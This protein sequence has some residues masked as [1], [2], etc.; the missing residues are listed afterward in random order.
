M[1]AYPLAML[2]VF[3]WLGFQEVSLPMK[4]EAPVFYAQFSDPRA[5]IVFAL[6]LLVICMIVSLHV[7]RSRFGMSLIAIKQNEPAAS[8]AGINALRWKMLAMMVSAGMGAAAGGLMPSCCSSSR[9]RR[10]SAHG[11][12]A[13]ADHGAVRRRW[14]ILGP[15]IGTVAVL[16]HSPKR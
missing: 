11:L 12:R 5:Y 4:R 10:C 16:V 8:A 13:D 1:L 6:V 2:Y 15:V 14:R 3:E 9:R 7:E